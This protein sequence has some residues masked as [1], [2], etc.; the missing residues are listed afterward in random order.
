MRNETKISLNE[1]LSKLW[2]DFDDSTLISPNK[3][4]EKQNGKIDKSEHEYEKENMV[5]YVKTNSISNNE[6]FLAV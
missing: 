1:Y 2:A 4:G 5:E 6:L 3:N